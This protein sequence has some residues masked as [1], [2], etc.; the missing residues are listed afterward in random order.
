MAVADSL[1]LVERCRARTHH[2]VLRMLANARKLDHDLSAVVEG[3]LA[4]LV[5]GRSLQRLRETEMRDGISLSASGVIRETSR[6]LAALIARPGE[7]VPVL[8]E[9]STLLCTVME[10]AREDNDSPART[11]L[12]AH[13]RCTIYPARRLFFERKR[14]QCPT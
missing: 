8:E 12:P 5:I 4:T 11:V 1:L 6:R 14:S 2:R 7:I 9:V 13:S 10:A 3:G